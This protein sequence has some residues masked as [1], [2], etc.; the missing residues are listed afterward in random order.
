MGVSESASGD[1]SNVEWI[2][3][4]SSIL[5]RRF[6]N[7]VGTLHEVQG[8]DSLAIVSFSFILFSQP[9]GRVTSH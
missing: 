1:I 2:E 8:V 3:S 6:S 9:P 4:L 7:K 5:L